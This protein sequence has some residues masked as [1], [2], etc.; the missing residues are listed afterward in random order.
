MSG[1]P[2]NSTGEPFRL[3]LSPGPS[4][5]IRWGE[6]VPLEPTPNGVVIDLDALKFAAPTLA[7][8]LAAS[9][10]VHDA[11]GKPFAIDPPQDRRARNYL[12]RIGL[13]EMMGLEPPAPRAADVLVPVTRVPCSSDV[14]PT[15]V[16]LEK[17]AGTLPAELK[18][19][20]KALVHALSELGGN[21]CSHGDNEHGTFVLAQRFGPSNLVLA[22]G[23]LGVGI[24]V[25]LGK[26]QRNGNRAAEAELIAEALEPGVTGVRDKRP[27]E[28]HGNGLP[29]IVERIRAL[30]MPATELTIWS[31]FGRVSVQTRSQP[32]PRRFIRKV[33]SYT[34]GT[35][36]EVVLTSREAGRA[37]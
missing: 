19:P 18:Q 14:E 5:R 25:H 27:N 2:R 31:G 4:P 3:R 16:Q 7:L 32:T 17:A 26:A 24:P 22:V 6:R 9:D 28:E 21:A 34:P 35:W 12:A 37:K 30:E 36:I 20:I 8:R 15:A 10:A 23:D 33:S 1:A 11:D 13:A 29:E